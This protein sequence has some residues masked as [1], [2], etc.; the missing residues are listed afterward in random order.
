VRNFHFKISNNTNVDFKLN[1]DL[2]VR[3]AKTQ[4]HDAREL[5]KIISE[6]DFLLPGLADKEFALEEFVIT[7]H[8]FND[9]LQQ[10]SQE[11]RKCE[12]FFNVRMAENVPELGKNKGERA[13]RRI[14]IPFWLEMD[15]PGQS[16]FNNFEE[17]DD[18]SDDKRSMVIGD[19][20]SGYT[21]RLNVGHKAYQ[22]YDELGSDARQYFIRE[23]L[24]TQAY[25]IAVEQRTFKG[26]AADFKD[27]L[28]A[29]EMHPVDASRA[30][31]E[32]IGR[33]L[34]KIGG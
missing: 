6:R 13:G 17:Y 23:Q 30:V 32:L 33:A 34:N 4:A 18:A 28:S 16:I 11:E 7:T 15:P 12:F 5:K 10:R 19:Q 21:F 3:H 29:D 20:A 14:L 2:S 1:I 24:L 31:N 27:R 8:D 9:I 26:H 22:F 25:L